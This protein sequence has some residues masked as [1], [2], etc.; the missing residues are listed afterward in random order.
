M[1]PAIDSGMKLLVVGRVDNMSFF[2]NLIASCWVQDQAQFVGLV[3]GDVGGFN[4]GADVVVLP[5]RSEVF[6]MTVLEGMAFGLPVVVSRE[7]GIASLI[8]NDNGE[9]GFVFKDQEQLTQ[10]LGEIIA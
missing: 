5:S 6:A 7:C 4:A 3:E 1:I 8:N 9:E 2:R 10:L